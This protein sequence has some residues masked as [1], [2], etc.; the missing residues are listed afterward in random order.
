MENYYAILQL[1]Y[2]CSE[3]DI[4]V[5]Y[6]KMSKKYHPD[7]NKGID[8]D[9]RMKL[10]NEAYAILSDRAK[11][12]DYDMRINLKKLIYEEKQNKAGKGERVVL[13]RRGHFR[14]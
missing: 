10:I 6:L 3:Q 9:N 12:Q 14:K 7:V 13:K 5:Q 1:S 4:R 2:D 8:A 11:K